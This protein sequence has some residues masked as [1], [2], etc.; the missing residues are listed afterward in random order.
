MNR[1][2]LCL[3][4]VAAGGLATAAEGPS[5]PGSV[6]RGRDAVRGRPALN[7]PIAAT[8][9]Y[10]AL[11]KQWSVPDRPADYARAVRDRYGLHPAPYEN[12]G[13]PMG[14]HPARG[15]QGPGVGTD[16]LLCHAGTVAGQTIVGLGNSTLDLEGFFADLVAATGGSRDGLPFRFSYARGTID[17]VGP[18]TFLMSLRDAELN[19]RPQADL[20]YFPGLC[21]DPPAWWQL[22]KK[23]TRDWTGGVDARSARIDMA[24]LLSP[25]NSGAFVKKQEGVFADIHAFVM[26]V[27]SPKYPFPVDAGLAARGKGLFADHCAACH[28]TYGKDWTYPNRVVPVAK[29]GTD[30]ALAGA[31]SKRNM[32][33]FNTSWLA[34]EAG[35]DGRPYQVADTRGYQAPPLDGVWATAPYFHN[36]SVPTVYHVLNSA[37]RPRYFTRSYRTGVDDYDPVKLG[38]K[39]TTFDAPPAAKRAGPRDVYDTTVP[40]RTNGGHTYGDDLTEDER[41]AVIEYLKTL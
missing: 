8:R 21:S 18:F 33:H 11:W 36:G 13:L 17:P 7:P 30:P 24:T 28:G 27:E 35:P 20:D 5:A 1:W 22:K 14:M 34:R 25:F 29:L 23:K 26:S 38:L 32:E 6:D 40:G 15:F 19:L 3:G 37:A 10:E 4:V 39:V 41:M 9:A 2:L 31:F 12:A 16:C